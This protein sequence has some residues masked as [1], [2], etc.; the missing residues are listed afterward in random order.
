MKLKAVDNRQNTLSRIIDTIL[1]GIRE[2]L[3]TLYSIPM[4]EKLMRCFIESPMDLDTVSSMSNIRVQSEELY[5]EQK[6]SL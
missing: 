1:L 2:D 4:K 3:I 5:L 6:M